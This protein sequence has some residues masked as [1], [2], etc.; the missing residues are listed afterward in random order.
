MGARNEQ[1][2]YI[3]G[4][5]SSWRHWRRW[6]KRQTSRLAR[7]LGKHLREDAPPRRTGGLSD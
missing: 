6:L 3:G 1:L 2:N 7:R 5:R 4:T